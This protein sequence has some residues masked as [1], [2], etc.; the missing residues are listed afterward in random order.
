MQQSFVAKRRF[1]DDRNFPKGFTRSGRF[2]LAEGNLLE[3]HGAAMLEL[4]EGT[5]QPETAEEQRFVL[6]CR[7]EAEAESSIEKVW[8]KYKKNVQ[9]KK[10]FHTVFGKKRIADGS[11]DFSFVETDN[12]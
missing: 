12:D 2:T 3:K 10:K 7:A 5:R 1:F 4:E 6:V 9:E 8:V 11:D